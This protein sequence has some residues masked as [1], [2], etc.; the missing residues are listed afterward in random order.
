MQS[1]GQTSVDSIVS[2]NNITTATLNTTGTATVNTLVVN[3]AIATG[4]LV[5]VNMQVQNN[6]V[7][8]AI[9]SNTSV[10]AQNIV[11]EGQATVGSLVSNGTVSGTTGLFTDVQTTTIE[12][13]G[14][15]TVNNLVSNGSISGTTINGTA[16]TVTSLQSSGTATVNSLVSNGAVSGTDAF[17]TS[18]NSSGTATVNA[19]VANAASTF[20]DTVTID[21][22]EA[23][24]ADNNGALVVDGGVGVGGNINVGGTD[25]LFYGDVGIGTSSTAGMGN[26]LS[27]F[28]SENLFGNLVLSETSGN[29]GIFFSDGTFQTSAAKSTP[30][31]GNPGTVQI[32]AA[33]NAFTGDS[34]NFFWD[35][36][37]PGLGLGTTTPGS[38]L[39]VQGFANVADDLSVGGTVTAEAVVSNTSVTTY[40]VVW[41]GNAAAAGN[42]ASTSGATQIAIDTFS[43]SAY[44]TAHYIVQVTDNSNS[45]YHSA[46]IMLIHDGVNVYKTEYNEIYTASMLGSFDANIIGSV[47]TLQFTPEAATSKTIRMIRT[48]VN[49]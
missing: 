38:L 6:L 16:A 31:Y 47:L 8:N 13:A 34:S 46:Q 9:E 25:S 10:T 12:A 45:Q 24:T 33:S 27:V 17:F 30:S 40:T 48:T 2:N 5:V 3:S 22:T 44:R 35:A 39:D 19:L 11:S 23:S 41:N 14:Q 1:T 43:T 32:A 20:G 21:G 49:V 36:A 18:I 15:A 42:T 28:G 29:V 7:A 37:T 4:N 26:V